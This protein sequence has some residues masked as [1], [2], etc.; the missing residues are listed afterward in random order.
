MNL[1]EYQAKKLLAAYQIPVAPGMP[2]HDVNETLRCAD[3]LGGDGWGIKAQVHAG[4][5]GKAGGVKL[6]HNRTEL[7]QQARSMLGSQ[8]KTHQSGSEGKPIDTVLVQSIETIA[9]ELYLGMLVDRAQRQVA[10]IAS[11][12]G[13]MDIEQVAATTPERI[14]TSPIAPATGVMPYQVR[15]IGHLLQLNR[16]QQQQLST[17][18]HNMYRLFVDK[19]LSLVEINPLAVNAQKHLS[20][21][22]AKI[23]IDDNALF[24][25]P[26]LAKE[27]DHRQDDPGEGLARQHQLNYIRLHGNIGCMVN[28][29]GLAMATMDVISL[30]GGQP[31]NFLDV[32]GGTT[33]ERVT[34]AFRIIASDQQVR[35]ILV[36]IFGGIVRC[37]LI[38]E[39]IINAVR[40]AEITLPIIVRLEGTRADAGL[41]LLRESGLKLQTA[42][43][44]GEAAQQA[45]AIAGD[46][47][48]AQ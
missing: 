8:L 45:I 24:R 22:D 17:L 46:N 43:D 39:G 4:G 32:G 12:D 2:A 28:G 30:H 1:H 3:A 9:R 5:R 37:D 15:R 16:E 23:S 7:E 21:L 38:A 33:A 34:E 40:G 26:A 14:H 47:T 25:Q 27:Y 10:I 44:L 31:A 35:A 29:A 19:D 13:G 20:V 18:L 36:N 41:K 6:V 11:P 42:N 48:G